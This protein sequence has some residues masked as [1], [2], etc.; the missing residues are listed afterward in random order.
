MKKEEKSIFKVFEKFTDE[1]L[2]RTPSIPN[3]TA[4]SVLLNTELR[5]DFQTRNLVFVTEQPS[6]VGVIRAS[7]SERTVV[8]PR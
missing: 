2:L 6:S 3:L 7:V 5:S 4:F 8:E 1:R